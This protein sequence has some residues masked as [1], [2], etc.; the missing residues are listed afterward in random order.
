MCLLVSYMFLILTFFQRS[1]NIGQQKTFHQGDKRSPQTCVL[2]PMNRKFVRISENLFIR[3]HPKYDFLCFRIVY[4]IRNFVD[5]FGSKFRYNG[6]RSKNIGQQKTFHQG[7]ERSPQV[8]A[9][10][11]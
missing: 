3:K 8:T 9:Q 7:D 10:F 4:E 1:K 5:F 6:N 2:F 11:I